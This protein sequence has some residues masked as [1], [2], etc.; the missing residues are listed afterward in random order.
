MKLDLGFMKVPFEGTFDHR[1]LLLGMVWAC[2]WNVAVFALSDPKQPA[3]NLTGPDLVYACRKSVLVTAVWW[4]LYYNYVGTQVLCIFCKAAYEMVRAPAPSL[5]HIIVC[6]VRS[7]GAFA[8]RP[9]VDCSLAKRTS[10]QSLCRTPR[11]SRAT[12]SSRAP[13]SCGPF[14]YTPCSSTTKVL[15]ASAYC[16]CVPVRS[17]LSTTSRSMGSTS[18]SRPAPRSATASTGSSLWAALLPARVE[19]GLPLR[20]TTVSAR[21]CWGILLD[22]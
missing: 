21:Q 20:E 9:L 14:G 2:G 8:H 15:G 4:I 17:I 12:R 7:S 6:A 1:K 10:R 13:C 19:T 5:L 3:L 16:T 18:G 22:S 11:D